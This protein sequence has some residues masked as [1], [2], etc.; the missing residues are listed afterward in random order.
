MEKYERWED[1]V[2]GVLYDLAVVGDVTEVDEESRFLIART[3]L[4]L[5][6]N[7]RRRVLE[8]VTFVIA[9]EACGTLVELNLGAYVMDRLVKSGKIDPRNKASS[10]TYSDLL[11]MNISLPLIIL[12]FAAM[13]GKSEREKMA[14]IAHEIAHY[15]LGHH[16]PFCSG[17]DKAEKEADDL[18]EKWDLP[19]AHGTTRRPT[20]KYDSHLAPP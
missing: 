20:G 5:P 7:V 18:I 19:P 13:E 10:V 9:G 8:E 6:K 17:G 12:N 3:L 4:K 11:N 15:V 2:D 14:I 16:K 1:S